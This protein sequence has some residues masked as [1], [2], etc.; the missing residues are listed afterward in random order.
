MVTRHL[1]S[2]P[3][4]AFLVRSE[5]VRERPARARFVPTL[6]NAKPQFTVVRR[7]SVLVV[8]PG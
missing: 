7:L 4:E 8:T 2:V 6:P 5:T 1:V 3:P